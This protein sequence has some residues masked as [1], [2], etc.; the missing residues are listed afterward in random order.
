MYFVK[1]RTQQQQK[2]S[3]VHLISQN[4][5]SSGTAIRLLQDEGSV[6]KFGR[7]AE[8]AKQCKHRRRKDTN[9][10]KGLSNRDAFRP[11][12]RVSPGGRTSKETNCI[13]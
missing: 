1:V 3:M 10:K 5:R 11:C 4:K 7:A 8:N 9:S 13:K 12:S 6:E 2:A